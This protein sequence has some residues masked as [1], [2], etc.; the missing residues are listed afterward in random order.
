MQSIQLKWIGKNLLSYFHRGETSGETMA[1][2]GWRQTLRNEI[3]HFTLQQK[4]ERMFLLLPQPH[5]LSELPHQSI[6][7]TRNFILNPIS[8]SVFNPY[9]P[10]YNQQKM[11]KCDEEEKK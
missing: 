10:G 9:I 1:Q 4:S 8:P 7:E 2:R 11:R 6:Q 3:H 5:H